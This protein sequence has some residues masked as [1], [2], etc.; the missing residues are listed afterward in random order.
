VF[1]IPFKNEKELGD[2][3][4][5]KIAQF[6]NLERKLNKNMKLKENYIKFMHEYIILGHMIE[7]KTEGKYYLPH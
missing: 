5:Q 2:S 6:Y 3:K 7:T 4:A 1:K